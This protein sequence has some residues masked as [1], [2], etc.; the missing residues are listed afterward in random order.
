MV[1]YIGSG[2]CDVADLPVLWNDDPTQ[3]QQ[4]LAEAF[5]VPQKTISADVYWAKGSQ[6][7]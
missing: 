5:N 2:I 3:T 1:K 4:Q 7:N 6:G